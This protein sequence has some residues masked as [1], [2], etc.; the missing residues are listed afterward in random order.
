MF[1]EIS[2][3]VKSAAAAQKQVQVTTLAA[4]EEAGKKL[5][6]PLDPPLSNDLAVLMYTS[7]TTEMPKVCRE[8]I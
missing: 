4:V 6:V 7:G 5:V 1:N 2:D 3:D 8:R